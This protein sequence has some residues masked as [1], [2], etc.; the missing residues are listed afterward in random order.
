[1][2]YAN[3]NIIIRS[4]RATSY[5]YEYFQIYER[6]EKEK[7]VRM[8]SNIYTTRFYEIVANSTKGI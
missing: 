3:E 8:Q 4:L 1:M 2:K 5:I 7:K 6:R